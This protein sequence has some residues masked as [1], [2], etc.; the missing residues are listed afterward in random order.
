MQGDQLWYP[1]CMTSLCFLSKPSETQLASFSKYQIMLLFLP[2]QMS[3]LLNSKSCRSTLTGHVSAV[4]FWRNMGCCEATR[5]RFGCFSDEL[6]A[7][8]LCRFPA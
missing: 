1:G 5:Q 7:T 2:N 6:L 3:G 8:H 4:V